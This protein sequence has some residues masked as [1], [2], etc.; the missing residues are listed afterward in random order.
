M[1][2][3][4]AAAGHAAQLALMQMPCDRLAAWAG[5]GFDVVVEHPDV[6]RWRRLRRLAQVEVVDAGLTA[7]PAGTSTALARWD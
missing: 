4:A 3:A 6:A 1:V 2:K 7:V 5:L